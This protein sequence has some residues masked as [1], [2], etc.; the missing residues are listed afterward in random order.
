MKTQIKNR[1][2][3]VGI[4]LVLMAGMAM[5]LYSTFSSWV[6]QYTAKA[7]VVSYNN[8]V[9]KLPDQALQQQLDQARAYN[10]A[11]AAGTADPEQYSTLLSV[12]DTIGFVDIPAIS[13]YL[14]ICHG[15]SSEVLQNSVGHMEGTSLP[16]GGADT[17]CVLA[18]HTG[19]PTASLFTNL[20]QMALGDVFYLHVLGQTLAYQ[21]DQIKVVLPEETQY[22]AI[23]PGQDY[24]TLLTCTPFG[25]NDH[26][27]LVRGVRI[28]YDPNAKTAAAAAGPRSQPIQKMPLRQI[29]WHGATIVGLVLFAVI[30]VILLAPARSKKNR[31]KMDPGANDDAH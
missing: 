29:L 8:A 25:V 30:G 3:L 31:Q 1:L 23:V 7:E 6:C 19:L 21:V 16:V 2:P 24:V 4:L 14:P 10:A 9:T 28:P 26:R 15:T 5:L 27:L 12:T 20:D 11:L 18:A 13:V 17:H 22:T